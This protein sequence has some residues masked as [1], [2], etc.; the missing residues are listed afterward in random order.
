M[1]SPSQQQ[2]IVVGINGSLNSLVALQRAG[3]EARLTGRRLLA[4][5]VWR[6]CD[7][8][9]PSGT[10]RS[11][12]KG[13]RTAAMGLLKDILNDVFTATDDAVPISGLVI[14][15]TAGRTLVQIANKETDLLVIGGGHHGRLRRWRSPVAHYGLTHA[16]CPVLAVPPPTLQLDL[17]ALTRKK[18][19]GLV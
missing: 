6:P 15:G 13:T 4:V 8:D 5:L 14:S 1:D 17:E 19:L 18:R 7:T 16:T 9:P 10:N 3:T 11:P 2:R 12:L